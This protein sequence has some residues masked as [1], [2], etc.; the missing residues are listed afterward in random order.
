MRTAGL[1]KPIH[2]H[3]AKTLEQHSIATTTNCNQANS[4][5]MLKDAW[6]TEAAD[7]AAKQN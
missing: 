5:A 1:V 4:D 7:S 2:H 6:N 3:T